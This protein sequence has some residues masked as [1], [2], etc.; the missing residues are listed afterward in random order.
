[1]KPESVTVLIWRA[2]LEAT[3]DD[4]PPFDIDAGEP[5]TGPCD[6]AECKAVFESWS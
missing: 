3:L 6:C 1:M 4:V 2:L 5:F